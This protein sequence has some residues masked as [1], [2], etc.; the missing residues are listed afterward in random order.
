[1]A[2]RE[3]RLNKYGWRPDKPDH[4]DL[5]FAPT[6]DALP[7][8]IDL[9]PGCPVPYDQG[10]LGASVGAAIAGLIHFDLIKQ[11]PTKAFQPSALFIYYN[12]RLLENCAGEDAGVEIRSCIKSLIQWGI[13]PEQ[14][15]PYIVSKFKTKP[16]KFAY[17]ST[18][19]HH[20]KE[21]LRINQSLHD[22]KACLADKYPFVFGISVYESFESEAVTKTGI[23][24][25]PNHSER[26][27]GGQTVCCVGY[28]DAEKRFIARNSI[29]SDWG[30]EGYF[31]IPYE[32]VLNPDLAADFW[33]IKF[34][35]K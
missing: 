9:R 6:G 32:Y 28:D 23:V 1:M 22:L 30:M 20:I 5:K 29:G 31:T 34:D 26:M 33:M 35:S 24:P 27:L 13:C 12:G 14:Y 8:R 11:N 15:C 17:S 16:S 21:Y 7:S 2:Q 4:R 25:M 10:E 19:P 3:L 18:V